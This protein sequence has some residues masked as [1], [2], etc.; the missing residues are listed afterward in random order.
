[1]RPSSSWPLSSSRTTRPLVNYPAFSND[2]ISTDSHPELC[3]QCSCACACVLVL[4]CLCPCACARRARAVVLLCS[5]ACIFWCACAPRPVH[6][7]RPVPTDCTSS[8]RRGPCTEGVVGGHGAGRTFCSPARPSVRP[9]VCLC[10]APRVLVLCLCA[11][12]AVVRLCWSCARCVLVLCLCRACAVVC[13]CFVCA[14]ALFLASLLVCVF[15]PVC[16]WHA[17]VGCIGGL[18]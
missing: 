4:A 13:L 5:R 15:G 17:G 11:S 9:S 2:A 8:A 3:L 10:C 6:P 7:V 14:V 12:C 1:M 18:I 16:L